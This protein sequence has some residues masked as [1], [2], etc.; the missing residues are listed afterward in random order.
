MAIHA[1]ARR[2]EVIRDADKVADDFP[3]K[4]KGGASDAPPFLLLRINIIAGKFHK[5][6][7]WKAKRH[8]NFHSGQ[9]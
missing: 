4:E 2:G 6:R 8:T 1:A 3:S 9:F 5:S 7:H